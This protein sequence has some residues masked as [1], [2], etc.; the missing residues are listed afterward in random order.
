[1]RIGDNDVRQIVC[2]VTESGQT[3][4]LVNSVTAVADPLFWRLQPSA[5]R[6]LQRPAARTLGEGGGFLAQWPRGS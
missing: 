6:Q 1:L 4:Y 2:A 5:R 3:S